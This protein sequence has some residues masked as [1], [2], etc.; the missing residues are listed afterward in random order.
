MD[1][2]LFGIFFFSFFFVFLFDSFKVREASAGTVY[3]G[4]LSFCPCKT[5]TTFDLVP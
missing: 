1:S 5:V 3:G 2:T 4:G